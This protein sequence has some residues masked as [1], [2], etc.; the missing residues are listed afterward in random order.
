MSTHRLRL[1]AAAAAAEAIPQVRAAEAE[2]AVV[3]MLLPR[4]AG[5]TAAGVRVEE[6]AATVLPRE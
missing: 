5:P 3:A 2:E 1:V 6:C 4:A